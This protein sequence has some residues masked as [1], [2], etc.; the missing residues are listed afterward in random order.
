MVDRVVL[1]GVMSRQLHGFCC[2]SFS[3]DELMK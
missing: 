1:I 2:G 3:L